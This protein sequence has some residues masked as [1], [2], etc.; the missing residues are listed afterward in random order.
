MNGGGNSGSTGFRSKS[1][2]GFDT[3]D[4]SFREENLSGLTF[5]SAG[6]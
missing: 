4:V 1:E 2:S 3:G 5:C 6:T